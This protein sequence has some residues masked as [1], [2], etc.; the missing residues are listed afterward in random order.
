MEAVTLRNE[1]QLIEKARSEIIEAEKAL[2]AFI[3]SM[4]FLVDYI[5]F[6]Q[7]LCEFQ[8]R[9]ITLV[10]VT[11]SPELRQL[12][13]AL[14]AQEQP[15]GAKPQG[16]QLTLPSVV[17]TFTL[18]KALVVLVSIVGVSIGV[19][20]RFLPPIS[21]LAVVAGGLALAFAP[22]L[23]S[24]VESLMKK[25]EKKEEIKPENLENWIV[26][27]ISKMRLTYMSARFLMKVQTQTKESLPR[28]AELGLDEALYEREK[29]FKET[30]PHEFMNI[31]G[32]IIV[33]CDSSIWQRKQMIMD[34]MV[35][36][37]MGMEMMQ[38]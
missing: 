34:A 12:L 19:E 7:V 2:R 16:Q 33:A 20:H 30:L 14:G 28:F 1:L 32:R 37:S 25:E 15:P 4:E 27:S 5:K 29:F 9:I 18:E 24:L 6:E 35:R 21:I 13:K 17:E 10:Q 26:D 36:S 31:I 22:Q 3:L 11:T 38:G 8:D 23:K